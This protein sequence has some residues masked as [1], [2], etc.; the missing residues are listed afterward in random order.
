ML[1][2]ANGD[3]VYFG[4]LQLMVKSVKPRTRLSTFMILADNEIKAGDSGAIEVTVNAMRKHI[5]NTGVCER[6]CGVL[7]NI[8]LNG[9]TTYLKQHFKNTYY[10]S[11]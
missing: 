11:S 9:K 6:G 10:N 3:A 2:R 8:T 5:N 7:M 1:M 4:T